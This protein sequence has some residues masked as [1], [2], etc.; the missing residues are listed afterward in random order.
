MHRGDAP[1]RLAAL[2]WPLRE[3]HRIARHLP[4]AR[5][6]GLRSASERARP[7]ARHEPAL[8]HC[9]RERRYPPSWPSPPTLLPRPPRPWAGPLPVGCKRL[10]AARRK[11]GEASFFWY[12]AHFKQHCGQGAARRVFR[13]RPRH[14]D[15]DHPGLV[16]R[17]VPVG[18]RNAQVGGL[19][20]FMLPDTG[21]ASDAALWLLSPWTCS[22]A[23]LLKRGASRGAL[24]AK[25]FGGATGHQPAWTRMNVVS[26][27]HG[28]SCID[29]LQ[30][31]SAFT[32]VSKDVMDIYPRKVCF[33][34]RSGKAMVKRLAPT[35]AAALLAQERAASHQCRP[36]RRQRRVRGPLLNLFPPDRSPMATPPA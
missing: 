10:K 13:R 9:L 24:E 16:H 33:L 6:D 15:H 23:R 32:V 29:Y 25:V 8:K 19:N 35:N 28:S 21:D 27:Q 17:R 36:G 2:R 20:H 30:A 18:P 7:L 14:A 26:A 11:P 3:L 34:P 22:S 5:K 31:P 4:P 1:P 12:D